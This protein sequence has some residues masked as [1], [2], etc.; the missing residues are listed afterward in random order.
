MCNYYDDTC[1]LVFSWNWFGCV[2]DTHALHVLT[3]QCINTLLAYSSKD[4][5]EQN[6]DALS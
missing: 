1:T 4:C 6:S 3:V 2:D 5:T